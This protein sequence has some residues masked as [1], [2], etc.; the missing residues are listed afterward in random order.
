MPFEIQ[1]GLS[2]GLKHAPFRFSI[3]AHHLETFD[4]TYEKPIDPDAGI[5]T[6]SSETNSDKKLEKFAEEFMRHI[7]IGVEFLPS[8][9]FFAHLG[10]NYQRRK[11]LQISSKTAAVGFS[12]GFG[13]KISRFCFSFGRASYH[14]AGA[15]NHFSFIIN[16]SDIIRSQKSNP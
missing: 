12:W 9:N 1:L 10:Y 5:Y 6:F 11:E 13:I 14:L 3:T 4:L 8:K 2:Q 7:I 16:T 15:S